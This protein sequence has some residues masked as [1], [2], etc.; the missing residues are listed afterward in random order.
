MNVWEIIRSLPKNQSDEDPLPQNHPVKQRENVF[1]TNIEH[2]HIYGKLSDDISDFEGKNYFHKENHLDEE[3]ILQGIFIKDPDSEIP[4]ELQDGGLGNEIGE[5]GTDTLAW[6][7]PFHY[8]WES[9]NHPWGIYILDKG[10]YY[11]AHNVLEPLRDLGYNTGDLLIIAA[12][13]LF[14][15]EFFHFLSEIAASILEAPSRFQE[16][17][18]RNYVD[19]IFVQRHDSSGPLEEALANAFAFRKTDFRK[20]PGLKSSLRNFMRNQPSGYREFENYLKPQ[21][22]SNGRQQLSNLFL[23]PQQRRGT[24]PLEILFDTKLQDVSWTDVP[25]RLV[26]TITDDNRILSFSEVSD[27]QWLSTPNFDQDMK[28]LKRTMNPEKLENKFQEAKS[29]ASSSDHM[30]RSSVNDERILG[31]DHLR[32]FK[33]DNKIRVFYKTCGD[34]R[35]VLVG[36][37]SH[38]NLRE[39]PRLYLNVNPC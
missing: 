2:L 19:H 30:L 5:W 8:N 12:R 39:Y 24:L 29:C 17:L 11:L 15:H 25:V 16:S 4:P 34:G 18:Y 9:R 13:I 3:N 31:N 32:C 21:F 22:F 33:V 6:Y 28:K 36:I 20:K 10:L 35:Q 38:P 37:R 27:D 14:Y 26:Y 23:N 7:R 1:T